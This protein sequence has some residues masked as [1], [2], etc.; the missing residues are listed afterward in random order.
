MGEGS[1]AHRDLTDAMV[2][3]DGVVI[4]GMGTRTRQA[5]GEALLVPTEKSAEAR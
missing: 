5:T 4:D 3:S 1:M 2:H